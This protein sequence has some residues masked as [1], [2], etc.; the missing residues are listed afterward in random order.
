MQ[1]ILNSLQGEI[2][3]VVEYEGDASLVPMEPDAIEKL[4]ALNN[5]R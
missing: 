5:L 4:Q 1:D 2:G 3:S